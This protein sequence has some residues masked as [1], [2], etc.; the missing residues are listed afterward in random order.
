MSKSVLTT[1]KMMPIPEAVSLPFFAQSMDGDTFKPPEA[2]HKAA[3]TMLDELE[4]WAGALKPLRV[5]K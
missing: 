2:A 1:L 3:H 5:G 4:R